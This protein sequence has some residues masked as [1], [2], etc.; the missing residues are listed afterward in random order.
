VEIVVRAVVLFVFLWGITRVVGRASLGELSTFELLLYVTMGD[1]VQQAVTQQDFSMT[2]GVLAVSVFALLTVFLSWLQ[3]RFPRARGLINGTAVI[4]V[5]D[6]AILDRECR[7]Q[8]LSDTDLIAAAR[9]QGIRRLGDVDL[10][11][12]EAD[13]KI[14]FFTAPDPHDQGDDQSDG[15]QSDES[16]APSTGQVG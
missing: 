5:R 10:A 13:G 15:Q 14:S 9:Q 1:L 6:G 12:L 16:G 8:R 4:V 7:R 2:G 11:V 3:F